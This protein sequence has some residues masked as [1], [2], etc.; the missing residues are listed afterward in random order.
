MSS[1]R[2]A[3]P[4]ILR[5]CPPGASAL[6]ILLAGF[7]AVPLGGTEAGAIAATAV[8]RGSGAVTGRVQNSVSGQ[9]LRNAR[10]SVRGTNLQAF[11]DEMG[12]FRLS[13][14]PSGQADLQ[15]FYTG[16]DT[17]DVSLNVPAGGSVAIQVLLSRAD[18]YGTENA[19]VALDPFVITASTE[20]SAE[21]LAVNEQRFAANIKN[22]IAADAFGDVSEGNIGEFMKYMPGITA[23]FADPDIVSISVRGLDSNL[24]QVTSDGSQMASAHTGGSTRVFQFNQVSIN[25]ISRLELTKVPTPA[26]PADSLGGVVN[27][28][29]KSAFERKNARLDVR[30]FVTGNHGDLSIGRKPDGFDHLRHR[31]LPSADFSYTLPLNDKLGMVVS[32]IA[33][34][35]FDERHVIARTYTTALANS[36]ASLSNPFLQSLTYQRMPRY[37]ERRSGSLKVDWRVTPNSVL[38]ASFQQS[39]YNSSRAMDQLLVNVGANA[40]PTAGGTPLR[41]GP[42]YTYGATGRGA[43]TMN[44]QFYKIIGDTRFGNVRYRFND[45]TWEIKAGAS[46]SS[47]AT[48]LTDTEHGTFY[49]STVQLYGAVG[50]VGS[51]FTINLLDQASDGTGRFEVLDAR[52]ALVDLR[53]LSKY[54]VTGASSQPRFVLDDVSTADVSVRRN[55]KWLRFPLALEIG[56]SQRAQE[57]DT[58]IEQWVWNYDGL[59]GNPNTWESPVPFASPHAAGQV[60]FGAPEM[61]W[62]SNKAAYNAWQDNPRLFSATVAQQVTAEKYR[63]ENSDNIKETVSAAYVQFDARLLNNRLRFLSGVRFE[64]TVGKGQGVLIEP[65]GVYVRNRDGSFAHDAAGRRVRKPEAGEVGSMAEVAQTYSER[66]SR[67]DRSYEGF[68]P[69]AHATYNFTEDFVLRLAYAETYGRPNFNQIIP[70][71]TINDFDVSDDS[72]PDAIFGTIS[73]R[74]PALRPWTA[75]NYDAS[76]E[77]YTR[78]GGVYGIGAYRKDIDGFFQTQVKVATPSDIAYLGLDPMYVG[79]RVTTMY[80]LNRGRTQGLEVNM[81]QALDELGSWGRNFEIFA[82]AAR[83]KQISQLYGQNFNAGVTFR[84]KPFTLMTKLNYR[85][86]SRGAKV[87][88]L[89]D[90]AYQFEGARTMVD[91]SLSVALGRRFSLFATGSNIFNDHPSAERYG[92]ETPEYAKFFRIQEF[93]AQYSAGLKGTF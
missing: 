86:G 57:R 85:T 39:D 55:M 88:A 81:R 49:F 66:A 58:R 46:N 79:Y 4:F 10:V 27:L 23:D 74:N 26:D 61:P 91:L 76:L 22:V 56:G 3:C 52:N 51:L 25:N 18:R 62:I 15:V 84:R 67:S 29:S 72:D 2:E 24:T 89:G 73:I 30:L 13:D 47:S 9:Y 7:A 82:N 60:G 92:S 45:G 54:R 1:L 20:F 68:Y 75:E 53:D 35:R 43:L 78:K 40:V 70:R 77:Y 41:F 65:N 16:L 31:I 32:G 50:F 83:F 36:G 48:R 12:V 11:T 37:T 90:D 63:L 44:G 21:A 6:V 33:S 69:S 64:K 8:A 5:R 93:G 14:V 28:I 59:D 38:S 42:D 87:A 71:A 34:N 19:I 17:A 80:N